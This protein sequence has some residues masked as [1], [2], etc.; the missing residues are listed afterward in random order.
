MKKSEILKTAL[1]AAAS[2]TQTAVF[3][4]TE[5]LLS[6]IPDVPE[7]YADVTATGNTPSPYEKDA[8]FIRKL[9]EN[10]EENYI[11]TFTRSDGAHIASGKESGRHARTGTETVP[12]YVNNEMAAEHLKIICSRGRAYEITFRDMPAP[13]VLRLMINEKCPFTVNPRDFARFGIT[14][15]PYVLNDDDFPLNGYGA[16]IPVRTLKQNDDF[17]CPGNE[18]SGIIPDSSYDGSGTSRM[19]NICGIRNRN[20]RKS[21]REQIIRASANITEGLRKGIIPPFNRPSETGGTMSG[22]NGKCH[23]DREDSPS[24]P[25]NR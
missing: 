11:S 6:E 5:P 1:T 20:M 14:A 13:A 17:F 10:A 9:T 21:F 23:L 3:A 24:E 8:E 22:N 15:V 4:F 12:V 16:R 18:E 19:K 2:L 7:S 25:N